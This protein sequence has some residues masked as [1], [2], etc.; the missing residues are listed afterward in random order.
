MQFHSGRDPRR[1]ET[2]EGRAARQLRRDGRIGEFIDH[3]DDCGVLGDTLIVV[4]SIYGRVDGDTR[5][6]PLLMRG[7]GVPAGVVSSQEASV[8]DV[9]PTILAQ[10]GIHGGTGHDG[11]DLT[12]SW[13]HALQTAGLTAGER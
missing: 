3:L 2:I 9:A 5:R 11:H 1:H 7:P 10:L 8:A 12:P 6:V 13:G 4:T